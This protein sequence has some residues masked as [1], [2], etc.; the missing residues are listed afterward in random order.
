MADES[1]IREIDVSAYLD[2]ELSP[3]D[4]RELEAHMV[5][6]ARCHSTLRDFEALRSV[7]AVRRAA[8]V[9]P[10]LVDRTMLRVLEGRGVWLA[11]L[12]QVERYLVAAILVLAVGTAYMMSARM[13]SLDRARFD[14]ASMDSYLYRSVDRETLEVATLSEA[15]LN[16]DRVAGLLLSSER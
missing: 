14:R 6:C 15:D 7:F 2:G 3:D 10:G 8:A 9:R 12:Q 11:P 4:A 5:T 1:C 13:A 16:R